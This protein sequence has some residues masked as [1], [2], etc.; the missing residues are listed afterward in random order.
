MTRIPAVAVLTLVAVLASLA[1]AQPVQADPGRW[2]AGAGFQVGGIHFNIVLGRPGHDRAGHYYYRSREPF[3][4][5]HTRCGSR[6]FH[7]DGY[8]YHHQSCPLVSR[9]LNHFR[10]DPEQVFGHYAPSFEGDRYDRRDRYDR[11]DRYDRYDRYDRR[12]RSG[13]H[14]DDRYYFEYRDRRHRHRRGQAC[15][16]RH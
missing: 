11:H 7:D 12:G 10:L 3:S 13:W 1:V 4:Y 6:C 2:H 15:P 14:D 8:D 9:H 5:R 16:Y